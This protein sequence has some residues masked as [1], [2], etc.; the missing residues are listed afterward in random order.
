MKNF[1]DEVPYGYT[2]DDLLLVP[3]YSDMESRNNADISSQLFHDDKKYEIPIIS[4]NMNTVTESAMINT[5]CGLGATGALHRFMSS[6]RIVQEF[7]K[8]EFKNRKKSGISI[9]VRNKFYKELLKI[10]IDSNCIFELVGYV[11]VDIAHG[12]HKL[13]AN[14]VKILNKDFPYLKIIA[15]NICTPEAALQFIDAGAHCAKAGIGAGAAC[16]TRVVCGCGYPQLSAIK[17]IYCELLKQNITHF[18]IISDGGSKT[19]GD[20]IK[21]LA[22]GADFVMLGGMLAGTKETPGPVL[23]NGKSDEKKVKLYQGMAS[24]DVQVNFTGNEA[25]EIASEGVSEFVSYKG[26]IDK[27]MKNIKKSLKHGFSYL[28]CRDI[29]ELHEFGQNPLNWVR[30]TIAGIHEGRPHVNG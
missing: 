9:G 24:T 5:I 20:I 2:F 16:K 30:Q 12:D 13:C 21:N 26:S 8:I 22:A 25:E 29:K 19:T 3:S 18:K 15:G 7:N 17:N 28:G 27:I 4:A 11:I 1:F 14:T 23:S 10:K 6:E